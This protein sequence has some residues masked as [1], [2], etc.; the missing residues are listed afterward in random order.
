MTALRTF[1]VSISLIGIAVAQ[2]NTIKIELGS[3]RSADGKALADAA[4]RKLATNLSALT[5]TAR[6]QLARGGRYHPDIPLSLPSRVILTQNG[7]PL[8]TPKIRGFSRDASDITLQFDSTGAGAFSQTYRDF[9]QA[10]F[11][12]AKTTMNTVF[13]PPALGGV[14]HVLNYDAQIGDRDAVGGGLYLPNNGSGVREIRFPVYSS[15]EA[16]GVNFI[17]TILLAYQGTTP[18]G[19]DAYEEGIVRAATMKIVRT[20]PAVPTLDQDLVERVLE[21][22]YDVAPQYDWFNQRALG[23]PKFIASN[24]VNQPLPVGGSLGGLYLLRFQMSGTAWEK[25]LIEY[26]TFI[27]QFNAAFYAQPALAN[28]AAGLMGIG[29]QVLTNLRPGDPTVEGLGFIEWAK[30]QC[31]LETH[32]TA[33]LK[34]L[35]QPIP[36]TSNLSGTDFG[37]FLFQTAF[38][39]TKANGDE[40]LLNG[41]S[42]PIFWD[43]D[44]NRLSPS[45]QDEKMDIAGAYGSVAP[46]FTNQNGGVPYRVAVDIPVL[47][48]VQR[49]YVPAGSISTATSGT[50]SYIYGTVIGAPNVPSTS[51]IV[52]IIANGGTFADI[53]VNTGAFGVKTTLIDPLANRPLTVQVIQVGPS[54]QQILLTRQVN[55]GV[56]PIALDLRVNGEDAFNPGTLPAGVSLIGFPVDPFSSYVP[57]MLGL[58]DA[59]TLVARYN[60]SRA[61]YDLY[62]DSEPFKVGLGYFVRVPAATPFNVPGRSTTGVPTSVTLRPGWNLITTPLNE[63]VQTTSILTL[64]SFNLPVTF[65]ESLGTDLGLDFFAF[66]RSANDPFSGVPE[67]GTFTPATAFAP[68]QGYLVRCLAPEGLTLL[69][70]PATP[71]I[72]GKKAAVVLPPTTPATTHWRLKFQ[73]QGESRTTE[74]YVMQSTVATRGFDRKLDSGSPPTIGGFQVSSI[75]SENLY[76]DARPVSGNE[77]Y[78]LKVDGLRIGKTYSVILNPEIGNA[79]R[80]T[81]TNVT[82]R[83]SIPGKAGTR[84]TFVA[85]ATTQMFT[86]NVQGVR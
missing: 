27:S 15:Q 22:S 44:F 56:G 17:H 29:Q 55:K 73:V 25:L 76:R 3:S 45:T 42:Y 12:N 63:T 39:Q 28:D 83:K 14:V 48:Q 80:M 6:Q 81:L 13:G 33:G 18:Y 23:G 66:I 8:S 20:A 86:L 19:F 2:T 59:A 11:D 10:I 82:D 49:V 32:N 38:F 65:A 30:R 24:L 60:S 35:V 74:A 53:P 1:L 72:R 70:Q 51:L 50:E 9:L 43:S 84:M 47:D 75:A 5:K 34:L 62:P 64:R 16:A 69:F 71:G 52:R 77:T 61:A 36:I 4:S 57:G 78:T 68:G 31:I 21:N 54:N 26:P 41:T 37:V 79:T 40:L 67:N 58:S 85:K 46:N 7:V